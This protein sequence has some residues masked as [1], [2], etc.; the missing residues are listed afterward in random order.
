M[1]CPPQAPTHVARWPPRAPLFIQGCAVSGNSS[2]RAPRRPTRGG[3]IH[4]GADYNP[5]QWP[6]EV[7]DEDIV[8]MQEAGVTVVTLA[9]FS[10]ARLQQGKTSGTSTGWTTSSA[11]LPRPVSTSTWPPRRR[12]RPPG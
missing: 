11:A 5:E 12:R 6:P 7:W 3:T 4:Y 9:V 1:G 8:L 2:S 10:W